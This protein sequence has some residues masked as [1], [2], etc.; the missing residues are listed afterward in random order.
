MSVVKVGLIRVVS[1]LD[2]AARNLHAQL[3]ET[4]YPILKVLTEAI[5]GF[6]D[7]IYSEELEELAVP[8][9]VRVAQGLAPH[10]DVLAVSCVAD[11]GVR[12]LRQILSIPTVGAGSC[13]GYAGRALGT[14]LG[15][16]TI[17]SYVPR[18][19]AR[20]LEGCSTAWLQV[21]GVARTTDLLGRVEAAIRGARKLVNN[22]CRAVAL[23]C[24]GFSMIGAADAIQEA[25]SVPVLDPVLT[26]GA[27][28][29]WLS[30][31]R[32]VI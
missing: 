30:E 14:K 18:A 32:G 5:D 21:E 10:V 22:G 3:L 6:P 17:G 13:L 31:V 7:G 8:E 15:L 11:P 16:L 19:V 1:S 25:V 23:A 27:V 12:E 28:I 2:Q 24:T 20:P 4:S 9:V 29:A 26:M